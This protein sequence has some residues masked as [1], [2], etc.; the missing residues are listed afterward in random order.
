[1]ERLNTF[2]SSLK[3]NFENVKNSVKNKIDE[4]QKEL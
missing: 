1:M 3:K 4:K 2:S